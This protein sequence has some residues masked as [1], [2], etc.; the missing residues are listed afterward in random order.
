MLAFS[1]NDPPGA[2]H[3]GNPYSRLRLPAGNLWRNLKM[4]TV[5][6]DVE[7]AI[8]KAREGAETLH[9]RV[10]YGLAAAA[11]LPAIFRAGA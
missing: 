11:M 2:R 10:G 8:G 1:H 6:H 4:G 7:K 3:P 5:H 9:R